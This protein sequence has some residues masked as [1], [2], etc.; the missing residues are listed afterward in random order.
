MDGPGI[1]VKVNDKTIHEKKKDEQQIRKPRL[2]NLHFHGGSLADCLLLVTR[3][4]GLPATMDS[5][6]A[7][8][9]LEGGSLMPS[10][11]ARAAKRAGLSAS[12]AAKP[13][14]G[15]NGLLLP[16]VLLLKGNEA[17]LLRGLDPEQQLARVVFPELPDSEVEI[18]FPELEDRYTGH[19]IY[20]RPELQFDERV[21][22]AGK[23]RKGHW[24]WSVI[25]E[26]RPLYRDLIIATVM[27]NIFALAMPLFVMNV[28]NR[29]VPN[30]AVETLWV[31]SGVV[32]MVL[33]ADFLLRMMRG[34]FVDLAAI[35]TNIKLSSRILEKVLGMRMEEKPS[36]VGSFAASLQSFESVRNFISSAAVTAY[37]DLPFGILFVAVIALISWHLAVPILAGGGIMILY[38]LSVQ[39][40][41][42]DLA[43]TTNQASALRNATLVENLAALET[44][45]ALGAE[46]RAQGRW[47]R[48]VVFLER[49][50][51][52]LRLLSSSVANTAMW[53]QFS[54]SVAIMITGVYLIMDGSL[55]MGGLIAAYM[56]SSRAMAPI[57]RTASL[58]TQYHSS[59]RA[60]ASM[61]EIMK[62]EVERPEG[63]HFKSHHLF[64]GEIELRGVSFSYPDQEV[65]V[66]KDVSLLIRPGEKVALLG[67]VGSG[68]STLGKLLLGLYRPSEGTILYDGIDMRQ[69]DPSELRRNVGY[70]PQDVTLFYGGLRENIAM[71]APRANERSIACA[72]ALG[73]L[74]SS[75][76][77]HP[78]GIDLQV[79]ER[80][81]RLSSGQRQG[82]AIARA[83]V[84][85]PPILLMDEPTASMDHST[86]EIVKKRLSAFYEGRTLIV[87][88]H[89]SS[90]LAL[91][92]RIVVIDEGRVV[93]DGP[94]D[95]VLQ[96]LKQGSQKGTS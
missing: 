42:R 25:A 12:I 13:L 7:G 3:D 36:S 96:A 61:E 79:G 57:S 15:I 86:E 29:V 70:V 68:K 77:S 78:S 89:K 18:S 41:M 63:I 85:D 66:L 19:V 44:V 43:Q 24:F 31:L 62:K 45:K 92:D 72:A 83:L 74:D 58:L 71:G 23:E 11:F 53:F 30:R 22:E 38:A 8:I 34:Y 80:G 76:N 67:R 21:P 46:G 9:P 56:L 5:L 55:S 54:V 59:A 32:L 51:A 40:K 84:K 52:R 88:T 33:C 2:E 94:R 82:V 6:L 81:E 50:G 64:R 27:I 49:T 60:L 93:M 73:G 75:I 37:V 17:C 14:P 95:D 69:L 47:E 26:N 35:R 87:V 20:C 10:S 16:A 48:V 28:Y 90:L 65:Q 91:V 39:G 4:H 1:Q